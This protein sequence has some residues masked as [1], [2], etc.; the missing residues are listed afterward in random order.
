[1]ID[2]LAHLGLK[3]SAGPP[4]LLA[5]MLYSYC[6]LLG[7]SGYIYHYTI[8]SRKA[9][10]NHREHMSNTAILVYLI[11]ISIFTIFL[12]SVS[13]PTKFIHPYSEQLASGSR[14]AIKF[15]DNATYLSI[16]GVL[17]TAYI[18][19]CFWHLLRKS[20]NPSNQEM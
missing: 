6:I 4:N 16:I 12:F 8:K 11:A 9:N 13:V 19:F 15:I 3:L 5:L 14:S 17:L 1:M 7:S 20:S 2:F 18:S 10:R